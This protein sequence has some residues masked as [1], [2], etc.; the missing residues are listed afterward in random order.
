LKINLLL[1]DDC[2]FSCLIFTLLMIFAL[3]FIVSD[4][5]KD[6]LRSSEYIMGNSCYKSPIV[7]I[8]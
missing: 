7:V 3:F 1:C 6:L 5:F 4:Y 8:Y 2:W